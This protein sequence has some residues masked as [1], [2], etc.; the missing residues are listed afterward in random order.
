MSNILHIDIPMPY[1]VSLEQAEKAIADIINSIKHNNNVK[2]CKYMGVNEF[3]DSSIK[4][5]IEIHCNPV[6]KLQTR[7]D[8]LRSILVELKNNSIDIP[9]TQIDIH[10]K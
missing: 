6:Y 3:A 8:A 1:E 5:M 9:Y 2:E 10:E 4:Y 7:R